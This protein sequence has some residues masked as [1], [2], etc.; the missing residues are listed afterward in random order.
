MCAQRFVQGAPGNQLVC[1]RL[2]T[3]NASRVI[4]TKQK[5][6]SGLTGNGAAVMGRSPEIF[7]GGLLAISGLEDTPV[8]AACRGE[9]A[10]D[11]GVGRGSPQQRGAGFSAGSPA[12]SAGLLLCCATKIRDRVS[13]SATTRGTE[14]KKRE[15]LGWSKFTGT[16]GTRRRVHEL[17]RQI[18]PAWGR[19]EGGEGRGMEEGRRGYL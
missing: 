13:A 5:E 15:V 12:N 11:D 16:R 18:S 17:R 1:I 6:T 9:G 7:A 2:V 19:G 14:W 8:V 4:S 3:E 10:G